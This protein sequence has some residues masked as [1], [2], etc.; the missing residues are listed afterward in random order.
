MMKRYSKVISLVLTLLLCIT[1]AAGCS[2]ASGGKGETATSGDS[3]DTS[4]S[5]EGTSG[6]K[7][8]LTFAIWDA[9]QQA[10][11][12]AMAEAFTKENPNI[13]VKV[14]VTPWDQ[15]W[16][17]L[18]AA[19]TG[20]NM[21]DIFWMHPEQI[22]NYVEGN[23]LM[24]LSDKIADSDIDLANYPKFIGDD[25]NIDGVQ[26]GIPKDYSTIGL[27]YNKD[28]FDA[29][30]V[31][32]PD[33]TWT[34]EDW[35]SAAEKL[36]DKDKGVYG[37]LA[38]SNSQNYYY[39]LIWQN[40]SD[41]INADETDSLYDDPKTIEA[42]KYAVSFIEK[43]FS[44]TTED[45]ANTTPDQYFESGKAAMI[46]AG[47]WMATEY[48]AIDGLNVDVAPMPKNVQRGSVCGGMG[49]S[50]AANTDHPEEAW[51]FVDYLGSLDANLIQS[52]SGAAIS[53][54]TGS[55]EPW[56]EGFP[57]INA[58]VFIDAADYGYSTQYVKSR[59]DWVTLE[60]DI[61]TQIFTGSIGVEDGCKQIADQVQAILDGK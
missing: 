38:P 57:D 21:P 42:I 33:D 15:Y 9:N 46:T 25:F 6:E 31:A 12:E 24:N 52:K 39:N 41:V 28:L 29:A 48:L 22:Y 61:M 59:R 58:Q 7:V 35:T 3:D 53:A 51:K 17:K 20:G 43:G 13:T 1:M 27:W 50:I 54:Y 45:F 14:E 18:N 11:M 49:Y 5:T 16:T 55:Q 60:E 30:G 26:Y 32:Y 36:T 2:S 37:M 56:A 34:W 19:A 40:G 47:S 44:P 23:A 8:N 4:N 10:G